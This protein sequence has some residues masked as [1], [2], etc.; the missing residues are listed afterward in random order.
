[1]LGYGTNTARL[2]ARTP[3]GNLLQA[4]PARVRVKVEEGALNSRAIILGRGFLD[5]NGDRMPGEDEPGVKD[6]RLYL[7]DGTY[8]IT[9]GEGKFSIYNVR[10]G[11]HVLK[12]D[13]A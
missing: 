13:R 3:G 2:Q 11:E 1:M 8:V 4:G 7:E 5:R 10:A 6:V 12:L 9:D